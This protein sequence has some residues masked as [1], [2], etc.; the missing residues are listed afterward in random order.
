MS[1]VKK[2]K[3][4]PVIKKLLNKTSN[5]EKG[6]KK[7]EKK[8]ADIE[9][10]MVGADTS[11]SQTLRGTT[12]AEG[13]WMEINVYNNGGYDANGTPILG[14]IS[15]EVHAPANDGTGDDCDGHLNVLTIEVRDDFLR[16]NNST[17]AVV[18]CADFYYDNQTSWKKKD[19]SLIG[20]CSIPQTRLIGGRN[21]T[22]SAN[23][24]SKYFVPTC[25]SKSW[26]FNGDSLGT[27]YCTNP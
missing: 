19:G 9:K 10:T 2:L 11:I 16:E 1:I 17:G 12:S 23:A 26:Y 7:L 27:F 24:W 5:L 3:D 14:I 25:Y 8:I 22:L 4:M 13:L 20:K 21:Y 18:Y 15:I 6:F